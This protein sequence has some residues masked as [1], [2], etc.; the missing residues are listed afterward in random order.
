MRSNGASRPDRWTPGT[1]AVGPSAVA[2]SCNKRCAPTAK[3]GYGMRSSHG[4]SS[5]RGMCG[6]ASQCHGP[7]ANSG[8]LRHAV[9]AMTWQS[10]PSSGSIDREDPRMRDRRLAR[11]AAVQHLVAELVLV[12]AAP[13]RRKG[14]EHARRSRARIAGDLVGR[15][16]VAQHR[17]AVA[18]EL[19]ALG[20][21]S[22]SYTERF[23]NSRRII[24]AKVGATAADAPRAHRHH[25]MV[26]ERRP[27]ERVAW[28]P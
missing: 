7:P 8:G 6:P 11:G 21:A 5:G 10:S 15:E 9:F 18:F 13:L 17:V 16:H 12:A 1:T 3:T 20:G 4:T 26:T 24:G 14:V 2:Q 25:M 28:P 23:F 27:E 19:D 22:P